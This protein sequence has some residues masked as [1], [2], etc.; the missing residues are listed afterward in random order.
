MKTSVKS[1]G[2]ERW[3][4]IDYNE[5][6]VS[7]LCACV[8]A[9][10]TRR[11][12]RRTAC[13]RAAPQPVGLSRSPGRRSRRDASRSS[14][15]PTATSNCRRSPADRATRRS[16]ASSEYS[17]EKDRNVRRPRRTASALCAVVSRVR[18]VACD[19]PHCYCAI[20]CN[21]VVSD[22]F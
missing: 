19:A 7:H 4:R 6:F 3:K 18:F 9:G 1:N 12:V 10:S 22:C 8:V 2:I 14:I 5:T 21:Q 11:M 17:A 20:G 13:R 15:G 16:P